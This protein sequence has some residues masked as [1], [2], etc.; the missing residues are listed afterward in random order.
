[1]RS[2]VSR[3]VPKE[4]FAPVAIVGISNVHAPPAQWNRVD[5]PATLDEQVDCAAQ[6]VLAAV[7]R[8][9]KVARVPH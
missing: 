7:G 8:L 9:D 4:L 2:D 6:S 3:R 5:C 1:M